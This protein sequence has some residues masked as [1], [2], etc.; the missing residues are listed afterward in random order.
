[1]LHLDVTQ[2]LHETM[3]VH[4]SATA[5][6]TKLVVDLSLNSFTSESISPGSDLTIPKIEFYSNLQMVQ[7]RCLENRIAQ[8]RAKTR[9]A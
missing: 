5:M 1:M 7:G 4:F 8:I 3:R 2:N 6:F 9:Q